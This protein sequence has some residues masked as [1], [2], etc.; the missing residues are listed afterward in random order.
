MGCGYVSLDYDL[1]SSIMI[2]LSCIQYETMLY[3]P[4]TSDIA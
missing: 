4:N 1:Q 3:E 2:Q